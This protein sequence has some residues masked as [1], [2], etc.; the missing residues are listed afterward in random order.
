MKHTVKEYKL[1]NGAKGLVV[2]VPGTSVVAISMAFRAGYVFGDAKKYEVPHV[3]EHLMGSGTAKYPTAL[4]FKVEVEKNGAYRNAS[5][6]P[7]LNT[8]DYE[9]ADFEA[10][11]IIDLLGEQVS[12][13]LF[14]P[15]SFATEVSNVNEELSRNTSNYDRLTSVSLAKAMLPS[16]VLDDETRISQLSKIKLED[17]REHYTNTHRSNNSFFI[18]SGD[19]TDNGSSIVDR[20]GKAIAG[21][22]RGQRLE[23]AQTPATPAGR[24]VLEKRPI[25]QLYYCLQGYVGE[26]SERERMAGRLLSTIYTGGY[27]SWIQ[28]EA[29]ERGLAYHTATSFGRAPGFCNLTYRSYVTPE[30]AQALYELFVRSHKRAADGAFDEKELEETKD[31]LIGRTTRSHQTAGDMLGWYAGN[32]VFDEEILDF[33]KYLDEIRSIKPDE[34]VALAN[35][36]GEE[37]TW[38]LSL[39]G[40]IT[41]TE[42]NKLQE[43]LSDIWS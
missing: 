32:Y 22:P 10:E 13:P 42:A 7:Y 17:V 41:K 4:Q 34:V 21:L 28:G 6:S 31:L 15:A 8:Y 12:K 38:G 14:P 26:L 5:T 3:M 1:A 2:N 20:L 19:F 40:D 9:C 33:Q 27:R 36:L 16:I 30:N 37:G 24:V 39:V 11:R 18:I 23:F 25:K 29:R 43:T 35:K